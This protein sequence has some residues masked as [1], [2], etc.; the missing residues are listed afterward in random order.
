VLV[1]YAHAFRFYA[2]AKMQLQYFMI[3]QLSVSAKIML[4]LRTIIT[5]L[6]LSKVKAQKYYSDKKLKSTKKVRFSRSERH[7]FEPLNIDNVQCEK[8]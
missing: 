8:I 2:S 3:Q 6:V 7:R 4:I 5:A 1:K